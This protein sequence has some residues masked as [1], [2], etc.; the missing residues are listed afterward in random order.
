MLPA[1][2]FPN[3]AALYGTASTQGITFVG[4]DLQFGL[5]V[6]TFSE[7]PYLVSE[8]QS[9]LFRISEST[10]V[11]YSG[12]TYFLVEEPKIILVENADLP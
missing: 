5:V 9:V 2:L 4:N 10:Q 1:R 7:T 8:G 11:Q 3:Y 12:Y 6:Q